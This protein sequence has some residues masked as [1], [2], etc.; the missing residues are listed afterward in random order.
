MENQRRLIDNARR[1]VD[2]KAAQLKGISHL[3]AL[4]AGFAMVVLVEASIDDDVPNWLQAAFAASAAV[5]VRHTQPTVTLS[6]TP[7]ATA[8]VVI[9]PLLQISLMLIS[10]IN[11]SLILVI[12]LK[13]DCSTPTGPGITP[14]ELFL[15]FWNKRCEEDWQSSFK[16]F[17]FGK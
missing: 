14:T 13:H 15:D 11:T 17:R 2:K 12:I 4:I 7:R 10:M 5:V 1:K 16:A 9:A 3:S 6:M 8:A